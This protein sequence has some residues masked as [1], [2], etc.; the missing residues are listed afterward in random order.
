MRRV[1]ART[2]LLNR[3]ADFNVRRRR[4]YDVLSSFCAFARET[5]Q[6]LLSPRHLGQQ[7]L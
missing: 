5:G 4:L 2:D 7:L 1:P 6:I 3:D